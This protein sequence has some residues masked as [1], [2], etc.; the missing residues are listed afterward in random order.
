MILPQQLGIHAMCLT[1]QPLQLPGNAVPV[2]QVAAGWAHTLLLTGD[3]RGL[4]AAGRRHGANAEPCSH[5]CHTC[6]SPMIWG[7]A[8]LSSRSIM[9]HCAWNCIVTMP[10]L[11][12]LLLAHVS[13][14]WRGH[15]CFW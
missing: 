1:P 10:L 13:C 11:V 7:F 6:H 3:V 8:E 14:S 15:L 4:S 5:T 9:Q 2:K 12:L